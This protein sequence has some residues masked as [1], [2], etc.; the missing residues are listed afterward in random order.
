MIGEKLWEYV[1]RRLTEWSA[2]TQSSHLTISPHQRQQD[3]LTRGHHWHCVPQEIFQ[4]ELFRRPPIH[5]STETFGAGYLLLRTGNCGDEKLFTGSR[6]TTLQ[7]GLH[8]C[9]HLQMSRL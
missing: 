5:A 2:V 9:T 1:E 4:G 7:P 6:L 3:F 8:A